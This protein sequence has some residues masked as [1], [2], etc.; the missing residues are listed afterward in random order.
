MMKNNSKTILTLVVRYEPD[1]VIARQRT[2]QIAGLLGFD[3]QD[4]TRLA[5]AVSEITR[6][7][8]NYAGGG[9][10]E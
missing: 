2:R 3:A 8:F 9:K 7:A 10:V 5:T 4:Q 1:I 6:N